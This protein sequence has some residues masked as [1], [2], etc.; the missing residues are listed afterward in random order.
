[1]LFPRVQYSFHL[2]ISVEHAVDLLKA[3]THKGQLLPEKYQKEDAFEAIKKF[4]GKILE[5]KFEVSQ[6]V[7]Q[8]QHFIPLIKGEF[9]DT[10][11][12]CVVKVDCQLF[13]GSKLLFLLWNIVSFFLGIF[14]MLKGN[15]MYGTTAFC[16]FILNNLVAYSSFSMH[17]KKC[18]ILLE[19]V[20]D[21]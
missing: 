21:I 16:C 20:F 6:K 1:M 11:K 9:I 17:V 19:E 13:F 4:N 8:G 14:F 18:K 3:V 15:L 2:P 10:G 5:Q 7:K 12:G